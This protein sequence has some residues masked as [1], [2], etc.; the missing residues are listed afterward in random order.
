MNTMFL[1]IHYNNIKRYDTVICSEDRESSGD[2]EVCSGAKMNKS[3]KY[4]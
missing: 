1:P 2:L 4:L 3:K